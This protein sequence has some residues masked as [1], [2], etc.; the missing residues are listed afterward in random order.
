MKL[1]AL[2]LYVFCVVACQKQSE[3]NFGHKITESEIG[4]F[5]TDEYWNHPSTNCYKEN[6]NGEKIVVNC[7]N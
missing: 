6:F 7:P 1:I 2:L 3:D 5:I 4:P